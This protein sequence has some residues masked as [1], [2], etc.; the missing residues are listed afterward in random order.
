MK[1]NNIL[2]TVIASLLLAACT[3]SI[4][5]QVTEPAMADFDGAR[6]VGVLPMSA[7]EEETSLFIQK[8]GLNP[9]WSNLYLLLKRDELEDERIVANIL[10]SELERILVESDY[11]TV[12]SSEQLQSKMK[13][14]KVNIEAYI[15]GHIN[16]I[17]RY[18][19]SGYSVDDDG[20]ETY[21]FE[22]EVEVDVTFTI[23]N[24]KTFEIIDQFDYSGYASDT[25]WNTKEDDYYIRSWENLSVD[26]AYNIISGSKYFFVPRTY[27]EYRQM[28]ELA[29]D[30][31]PRLERIDSLIENR[32][33]EEAMDLYVEIYRETG[34][35]AARY[36]IIL[37]MEVLG[38]LDGAYEAMK[39]Y[40]K[41]TGDSA[42]SR[43]L[44]RMEQRMA[45]REVLGF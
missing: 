15:S 34:D 4:P 14:N 24:T 32:F 8:S 43:Q 26:A 1:L 25:V 27:T 6:V 40:T 44:R 19:D 22:R 45:D 17:S 11:Y 18:E 10:K 41:A 28:A 23:L 20:T 29:N 16:D 7:T 36:N 9:I 3:T 12:I 37:I 13:E 39:E 30:E 33:Y 31:D 21:W 2:L 38:D 42:G 5:V 35:Q